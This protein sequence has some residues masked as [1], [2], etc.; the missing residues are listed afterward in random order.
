MRL[1]RGAYWLIGWLLTVAVT[2]AGTQ[3]ARGQGIVAPAVPGAATLIL[4]VVLC[5][6]GLV[7]ARRVGRQ[8]EGLL[9]AGLGI[10]SVGLGLANLLR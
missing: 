9:V 1:G 5:V 3:Y 10:L 2:Y 4:G 8:W 6:V 7:L